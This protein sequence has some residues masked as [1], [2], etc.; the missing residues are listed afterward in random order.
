MCSQTFTI[1]LFT[2]WIKIN[3]LFI[4]ATVLGALKV[5]RYYMYY[6]KLTVK[7]CIYFIFDK[8]QEINN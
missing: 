5:Y 2:F 8:I 1:G 6:L 7:L 3:L 4:E